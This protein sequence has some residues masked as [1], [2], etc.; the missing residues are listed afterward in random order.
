MAKRPSVWVSQPLFDDVIERLRSNFQVIMSNEVKQ[1]S[2]DEIADCL[3]QVDG[4]IVTINEHIG[5]PEV[6]GALR[7]RV[8][9]NVG[10]GYENLDIEALN[11]LSVI[12][13]NT[14]GVLTETTADFAFG[15]LIATARRIAE[16]DRWIRDGHWRQWSFDAMLGAD[17]HRSVLGILGMGRIGQAVARR[18]IGFNMRVLYHNRNRLQ[19]QIEHNCRAEYVGLDALLERSDHLLVALPYSSRIH[20][21]VGPAALARMKPTATLVN[22][23]HGGIVDETALVNALANGRLAAAGL[24]VFETEPNVPPAL[25]ALPNVVLTPH[26]GSA[27]VAARRAMA[28]LAVDNLTAGLGWGPNAGHPPTPISVKSVRK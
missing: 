12:A 3:R 15:L 9:A 26:I 2:S 10:V 1:Y 23:A 24:D 22:I 6:S 17:L 21:L 5:Y 14:P 19:S 18:A 28:T 8:I 11:E 16:S 7:L 13:T 27:S 25:L 4:A 20:H